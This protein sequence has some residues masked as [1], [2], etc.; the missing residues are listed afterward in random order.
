MET[1]M[2]NKMNWLVAVCFFSI[3]ALTI[4]AGALV[5]LSELVKPGGVEIPTIVNVLGPEEPD[6]VNNVKE[7]FRTVNSILNEAD[8][9]FNI[10]WIKTGVTDIGDGDRKLS[11]DEF[12]GILLRS[13][14]ELGGLPRVENDSNDTDAGSNRENGPRGIGKGIMFNIADNVWVE[15]PE[16][17][18]W[19]NQSYPV[20][21][22][23]SSLPPQHLGHIVPQQF[24]FAVGLSPSTDPS[25]FMHPDGQG[26]EITDEQKSSILELA[27]QIG[28]VRSPLA[29]GYSQDIQADLRLRWSGALFEPESFLLRGDYRDDV[30]IE[31][32]GGS[33]IGSSGVDLEA[34]IAKISR[35]ESDVERALILKYYLANTDLPENLYFDTYLRIPSDLNCNDGN[36]DFIDSPWDFF[37][38]AIGVGL[39]SSGSYVGINNYLDTG[40]FHQL[41]GIQPEVS[42]DLGRTKVKITAPFSRLEPYLPANILEYLNNG[43][44]VELHVTSN[45]VILD[46][47]GGIRFEDDYIGNLKF[48]EK[49]KQVPKITAQY[50]FSDIDTSALSIGWDTSTWILDDDPNE[51]NNKDIREMLYHPPSGMPAGQGIFSLVNFNTDSNN[52]SFNAANGFSNNSYPGIDLSGFTNLKLL[53]EARALMYIPTGLHIFGL[54]GEAS[55][56]FNIGPVNVGSLFHYSRDWQTGFDNGSNCGPVNGSP[57]FK[58]DHDGNHLNV[59]KS[60]DAVFEVKDPGLFLV[61]ARWLSEINTESSSDPN[62][63]NGISHASLELTH[64]FRDGMKTL[65]GDVSNGSFTAY[66]PPADIITPDVP[67]EPDMPDETDGFFEGFESGIIDPSNRMFSGNNS[68]FAS[69]AQAQ[70]G[71]YSAQAGPIGNNERSTIS[72]SRDYANAGEISFWLK[73]SSENNFDLLRFSINGEVLGEW[74]GELDWEQVVFQ[75]RQGSNNFEWTYK[76]DSN[77]SRGEDTAWIDDITIAL[78]LV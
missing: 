1:Y 35:G 74:S 28:Y 22:L 73:V 58:D 38:A 71:N 5:S 23:E 34:F 54:Q 53:S 63:P 56:I 48:T 4:Q 78:P 14:F 42:T 3:P 11:E 2:K 25:N 76:K 12:D 55:G 69:T 77:S 19:Y 65:L 27:R 31:D 70:S 45:S 72:F 10:K 57:S 15:K 43:R 62:D 41:I 49:P 51:A 40:D 16:I 61:T 17:T 24:G 33:Q 60:G 67:D 13:V 21:F 37:D 39:T 20:A 36:E 44:G 46:S 66:V 6:D 64:L 26:T 47:Q 29:E 59:L 68:W 18:F 32:L 50:S 9:Q 7:I 75:T 30:K 52:D 8:V